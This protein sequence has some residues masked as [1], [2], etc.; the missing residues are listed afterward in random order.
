MRFVT[1]YSLYVHPG[2]TLVDETPEGESESSSQQQ[3]QQLAEGLKFAY[4]APDKTSTEQEQVR[5]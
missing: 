1:A 3:Q 4:D 2:I 5:M